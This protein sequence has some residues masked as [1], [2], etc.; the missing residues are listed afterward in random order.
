MSSKRSAKKMVN[1][2]LIMDPSLDAKLR[3][4]ANR[5]RLSKQ[6]VMRMSLDR[7]IDILLSQLLGE[8]A[9]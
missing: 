3:S 4:A 9:A 8:N 7:G 1:H 6:A 5:T 2:L